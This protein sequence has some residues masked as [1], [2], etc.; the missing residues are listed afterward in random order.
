M[1]DAVDVREPLTRA[2]NVAEPAFGLVAR[3]VLVHASSHEIPHRHVEMEL[4]LVVHG[5]LD[6]R[7]TLNVQKSSDAA[8][9]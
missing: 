3:F 5:A 9:A 6:V 4:Q 7:A 8:E 1:R 2:L